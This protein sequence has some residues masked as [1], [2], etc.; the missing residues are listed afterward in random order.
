MKKNKKGNNSTVNS[1][2]SKNKVIKVILNIDFT[3]VD[4]LIEKKINELKSELLEIDVPYYQEISVVLLRNSNERRKES[5]KS[6]VKTIG[7]EIRFISREYFGNKHYEK[8]SD[9]IA[10]NDI[11]L[12]SHE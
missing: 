2:E 8:F 1:V 4:E 12:K 5:F 11:V 3:N 10:K 6:I 7:K 9:L